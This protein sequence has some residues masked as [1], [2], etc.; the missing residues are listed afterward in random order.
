M[1][2]FKFIINTMDMT[3]TN[4]TTNM[5]RLDHFPIRGEGCHLLDERIDMVVMEDKEDR[6]VHHL[7]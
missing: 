7:L 1:S 6:R 4:M 5:K 2:G 3:T